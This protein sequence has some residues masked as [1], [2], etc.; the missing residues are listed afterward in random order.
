MVINT[1]ET[2]RLPSRVTMRVLNST[3]TRVLSVD[4]VRLLSRVAKVTWWRHNGD[5]NTDCRDI[6]RW[7][8]LHTVFRWLK[9]KRLLDNAENVHFLFH[10]WKIIHIF[11]NSR[12]RRRCD[13]TQLDCFT[14]SDTNCRRCY[15]LWHQTLALWVACI[16]FTER[17]LVNT[18]VYFVT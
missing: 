17:N 12:H 8:S 13:T 1:D 7:N 9:C 10:Q 5:N 18:E 11:Q 2:D 4:T 15:Q 14:V 6:S 16:R 3:P